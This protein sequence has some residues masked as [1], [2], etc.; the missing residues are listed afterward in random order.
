MEKE[1]LEI[2]LRK[3]RRDFDAHLWYGGAVSAVF[4]VMLLGLLVYVAVQLGR[5][6]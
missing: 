2:E 6:G 1:Q 4:S 3:L 5:Q